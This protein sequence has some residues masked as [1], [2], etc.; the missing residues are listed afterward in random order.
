VPGIGKVTFFISQTGIGIFTTL[1]QVKCDAFSIW[2]CRCTGR[3]YR[4]EFND[5]GYPSDINVYAID[6]GITLYGDASGNF[7]SHRGVR[8]GNR[9]GG[10]TLTVIGDELHL[11]D[12]PDVKAAFKGKDVATCRWGTDVPALMEQLGRPLTL[13]WNEVHNKIADWLEENVL[14]ALTNMPRPMTQATELPAAKP[15]LE[16]YGPLYTWI[17]PKKLEKLHTTGGDASRLEINERK[18][19]SPGLRLVSWGEG[20]QGMPKMAHDGYIWCGI[21]EV[22]P[23][24]DP[25]RYKIEGHAMHGEL[26]DYRNQL[27]R[28]KPRDAEGLF[29]LDYGPYDDT[30]ERFFETTERLTREQM[31]EAYRVLIETLVPIDEYRGGY[32]TPVVLSNRGFEM[33]E[34]EIVEG[35]MAGER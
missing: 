2:N 15:Y 30:R 4:S 12:A 8:Y 34:I 22:T 26:G 16:Q 28:L 20:Y 31:G 24:S 27:V 14:G 17:H 6:L 29:V 7:A 33:D 3:Q 19:I 35:V 9:G 13:H 32:K 21:G 23:N 11:S 1:S 10:N 5:I 25:E 18:V